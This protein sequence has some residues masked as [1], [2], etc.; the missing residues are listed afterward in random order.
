MV[1]ELVCDGKVTESGSLPRYHTAPGSVDKLQAPYDSSKVSGEAFLNLYAYLD[2]DT[3][4][5]NK[6]ACIYACQIEIKDSIN[7][8][9]TGDIEKD[10]LK[11]DETAN[12]IHIYNE[13]TMVLFRKKPQSSSL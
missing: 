12:E 9:H 1:W 4:Y 10:S 8:V 11:Y 5:S 6:G 2:E 13:N 3:F 7:K